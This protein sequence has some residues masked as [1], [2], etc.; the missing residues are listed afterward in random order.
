MHSPRHSG[1]RTAALI[2]SILA[3]GIVIAGFGRGWIWLVCHP[4]VESLVA[5]L[6]PTPVTVPVST[7]APSL[8]TVAW[9]RSLGGSGQF[10]GIYG[11][12]AYVY[13]AHADAVQIIHLADGEVEQQ[14][15]VDQPPQIGVANHVLVVGEGHTI[16]GLDLEDLS[17]RWEVTGVMYTKLADDRVYGGTCDDDSRITLVSAIAVGD[18]HILWQHMVDGLASLR[19][20]SPGG[21]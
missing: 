20:P 21:S 19:W 17:V 15:A 2:L 10:F 4:L 8:L 12:H 1:S 18:G 14:Q 7:T 11:D 5:S 16:R 13:N 6:R 3:I 9:A